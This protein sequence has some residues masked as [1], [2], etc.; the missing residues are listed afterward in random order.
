[1]ALSRAEL[2][3][4]VKECLLEILS[5]GLGTVAPQARPQPSRNPING[6]IREQRNRRPTFDPRLDTPVKGASN[7]LKEAIKRGSGGNPMLADMLADT[8]MT[9][10]PSQLSGGDSM[11]MPSPGGGGIGKIA[12]QEQ[13]SGS[14]EE[15]F[16][17][18]AMPRSDGSSHWADLAF[19]GQDKKSA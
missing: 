2:K 13:F 14:P 10:L 16:G 12:Q 19:M 6:S 3:L 17:E 9:T 15:V 5:E 18:A 11:G 7:D 1:M 8:A 4:V